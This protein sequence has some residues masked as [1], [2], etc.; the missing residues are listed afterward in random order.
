M[1]SEFVKGDHDAS[2][3]DAEQCVKGC[4]AKPRDTRGGDSHQVVE[5]Q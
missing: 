4:H 5:D 2:R 3:C 1:S